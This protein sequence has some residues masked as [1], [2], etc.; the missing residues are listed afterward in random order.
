MGVAI[1]ISLCS[2]FLVKESQRLQTQGDYSGA[3][4]AMEEAEGLRQT[5]L[6]PYSKWLPMASVHA[7]VVERV[8]DGW[9]EKEG[10]YE[11]R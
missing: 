7:M 4:V 11:R 3:A 10:E 2:R 8:R 6:G 1:N 5:L 9:A